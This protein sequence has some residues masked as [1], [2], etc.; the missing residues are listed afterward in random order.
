MRIKNFLIKNMNYL[1][2]CCQDL[3]PF[4]L[5]ELVLENQPTLFFWTN[6]SPYLFG[7]MIKSF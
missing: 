6:P 3:S 1:F 7:V 2:A 4:N 5:P